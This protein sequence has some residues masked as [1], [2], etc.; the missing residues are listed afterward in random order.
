MLTLI[1]CVYSLTAINIAGTRS[2][3]PRKFRTLPTMRSPR[4]NKAVAVKADPN[5]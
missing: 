3:S 2:A 1:K 5:A 4:R